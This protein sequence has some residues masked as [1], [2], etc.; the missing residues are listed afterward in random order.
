MKNP[1]AFYFYNAVENMKATID[2]GV[3]TVRDTGLA[4]IG[5]KMAQEENVSYP[6]ID[7]PSDSH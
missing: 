1:L 7:C 3:T 2:A 6:Y 4:D 5:V